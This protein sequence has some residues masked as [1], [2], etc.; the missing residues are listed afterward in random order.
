MSAF[1]PKR[2]P[3][4]LPI[5]GGAIR[6]HRKE[7]PLGGEHV[8]MRIEVDHVAEGLKVVRALIRKMS[9]ANVGWG[10]PRCWF[11]SP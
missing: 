2:P 9:E 4:A 11:T 10:S 8:Q 1:D 3:N 6:D 5:R 7:T